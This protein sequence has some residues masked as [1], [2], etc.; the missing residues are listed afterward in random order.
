MAYIKGMPGAASL[1]VKLCS[2]LTY[3]EVKDLLWTT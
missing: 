3:E 1:K 2:A